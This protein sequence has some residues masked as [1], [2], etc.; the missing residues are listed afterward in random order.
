VIEQLREYAVTVESPAE[1]TVVTAGDQGPPGVPGEPGPAGG[2]AFQ[3]TAGE[4]TSALRVLYEQGG[5]VYALD[6][7]DT[8]HI[9][10]ILGISLTAAAAGQP[11]NVQRSGVL[12]DAGWSWTPGRV[13]LGAN[14]ALTQTPPVDGFDVLIGTAVSATRITLDI[15]DPIEL[16]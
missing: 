3:R 6:Y 4:I 14:G 1:V 10:L 11:L 12:D 9:D 15:T 8:A 5:Q 2:S 16:E 7:R 13:W